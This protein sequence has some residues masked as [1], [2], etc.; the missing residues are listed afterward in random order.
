MGDK[1]MPLFLH[2][3]RSVSINNSFTLGYKFELTSM[4]T[5]WKDGKTYTL[6]S[7]ASGER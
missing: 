4:T 6:P 1:M 7:V 2:D 5:S 3:L